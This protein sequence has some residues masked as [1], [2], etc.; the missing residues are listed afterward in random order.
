MV[1]KGGKSPKGAQAALSHTASLA[2][3]Q[4]IIKSVLAQ[5][6]VVEATD[7]KQMMDLCRSLAV[8]PPRRTNQKT[9]V[10]ILTFSGGAGIVSSDFL[11]SCG[12]SVAE[13]VP[14]NGRTIRTALPGMDAR[15]QPSRLM[16]SN[17]KTLRKGHVQRSHAGRC[18]RPRS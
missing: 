16:A 14:Q 18:R 17:G 8:N 2:G 11:Y 1:L 6:G 15:Y 4:A 13:L 5:A 12:I 3:N 10:A 7:F 9:G